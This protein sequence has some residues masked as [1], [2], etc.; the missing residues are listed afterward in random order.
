MSQD[1][2]VSVIMP[3]YNQG[4]YLDEAVDSVLAQTLQ[5]FE[6][7]VINDGSTDPETIAHLQH[8]QRPKV[9]VLHTEN[10]GVAA[11]RNW[12][13]RHASG[14]YILPLDADDRIGPT[15]LEQAVRA[16]DADPRLGIVY[17]QA[18]FFGEKTGRV[19]L[20]EFNFPGI[21]L[22]NM[23]FNSSLY[24]RADW[25]TVGGYRDNFHWEDYDFWL[26]LLEL[27]RTVYHIPEVLYFYRQSAHSRSNSLVQQHWVSDYTR[28]F[29]THPKLYQPNIH[30]LFESLVELRQNVQQTHAKL[31]ETEVE[32]HKLHR[33]VETLSI[34]LE[35]FKADLQHA[36]S[37]I[38]GMQS[39]KFWQLR[40][41][42]FEV[43]YRLGLSTAADQMLLP[44]AVKSGAIRPLP[45]APRHLH[46]KINT[47]TKVWHERGPVE[48]FR[49][50]QSRLTARL[51]RYSNYQDWI[52]RHTL[53]PAD[54]LAANRQLQQWPHRP[55]F[56][57]ILPVYNVEEEWL[58]RAIESVRNQ[59]YPDWELCI[60]D[61]ASPAP[62][63]Q[64]LLTHYSKLDPRIKVVFRETNG[65]IVAASNSALDLA[66]GDYIALLDHDD[67][68]AINALFEAAKLINQ[69]PEADFIYTD[70]DKIDT[71]GNRRDPFFKPDWSPDYFHACMY[72][73]HLGVYRSR[74]VREIGGFRPGY[75]GSQDYDLVLRL[76]ERTQQIY[77][78]PQVL[79][80]W[81][82]LPQSVTSGAEAKPWAYQAAVRALEDMVARSPY[83][84][85][86]E[87]GV[88]DGFHRV[89]R[90]IIG[91]PLVSI[92]IPTAGTMVETPTGKRCGVT[93]CIQ[94]V[95]DRST[96]RKFEIILVDGYDA[97]DPILEAIQGNDLHLVRCPE[98]FNFSQ[99]INWGVKAAK[100]EFVL[101]L[102]DDVEVI[103]P[104]WI[105]S[106]LEF[107]QQQE[108]GA[109][110][111]KLLFPNNT[112]QHVGVM[113]IH[114]NPGHAYR[115]VE[116]DHPGYFFSNQVNRNYWV[117]TAACLMMRR[118]LFLDLGL[119]DETFPLN[120]NDVDLCL[121]AHQKG[122]RN[123]VTPYAQ[124][125]HYESAS[126]EPGLRPKEW[127]HL[128]AK[129]SAYFKTFDQQDPYYNP[130]LSTDE[131]RFE[132]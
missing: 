107:A 46:K 100:G 6:I 83:P 78:I 101:L 62:H 87:A 11:A 7:I 61:D 121:K 122:Y 88:S 118:S 21:L 128:N 126:R 124:L 40:D 85:R 31:Y 84:G 66:T 106:M 26:S 44:P 12:G 105:E 39:S 48:F 76:V 49:Y 129:W 113:V 55:V 9:T 15:Y 8:Y 3:C 35:K 86:V 52:A 80:H 42:W 103:T 69:H 2:I 92:V 22:G 17:C 27:D 71:Q 57:V 99:R 32:N 94:S 10:R 53:T 119:M 38:S 23:I 47:L 89:R 25:E 30:V 96:Y 45:I 64:P 18:E 91:N 115:Q 56:S 37:A 90:E 59:I 125:Y 43:R 130:N 73:C 14:R 81:R 41:R 70:E 102:N 24:R 4:Q 108:I 127:E 131:I 60:A 82:I 112:I 51:R 50:V 104:D 65:N 117:V 33:Q 58:V 1:V 111:A 79:Y 36:Q 95:R 16:L 74:L 93:T 19:E 28:L 116:A 67:E 132:L 110:G 63:I 29:H 114:G 72:T 98:P 54:L 5:A 120:Y 123:V 34:K 109:V 20:P 13:I 97:P 68:L 77:H 75:D